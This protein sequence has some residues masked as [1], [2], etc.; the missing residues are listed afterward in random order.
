MLN[1]YGGTQTA[2]NKEWIIA[3]ISAG[4]T[5]MWLGSEQCVFTV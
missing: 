1:A 2:S 4:A 5:Q 3:L